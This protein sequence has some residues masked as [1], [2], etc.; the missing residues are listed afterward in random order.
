MGAWKQRKQVPGQVRTRRVA[1]VGEEEV[2]EDYEHIDKLTSLGIAAGTHVQHLCS[3]AQRQ[4][5]GEGRGQLAK[6]RVGPP[7]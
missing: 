1:A 5:A 2:L 4:H 6:D 7:S 3:K